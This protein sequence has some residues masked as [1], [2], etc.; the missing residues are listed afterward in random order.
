MV[1]LPGMP[2]VSIGMNDV[3][4]PAL[5]ADSGAATPL[6]SPLPNWR[7]ALATFFSSVYAAKEASSAPPPGSTPRIA[8]IAVPRRIEPVHCLRSVKLGHTLPTAPAT[9]LAACCFS[10]L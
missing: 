10:R 2:K 9:T 6:M 1:G 7:G 5:L 8:P 4:A 3:C